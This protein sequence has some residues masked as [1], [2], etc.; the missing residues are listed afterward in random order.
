MARSP[1]QRSAWIL[2]TVF[3]R[4]CEDNE[5]IELPYLAGPGERMAIATERQQAFFEQEPDKTDRDWI[6][7]GFDALVDASPVAAGLFDR[8]AQPDVADHPLA[9]RS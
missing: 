1:R 4:F 6:I 3:L 5:L 2:G 9:R 7:A 8:D